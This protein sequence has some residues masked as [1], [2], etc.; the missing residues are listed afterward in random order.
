VGA[1]TGAAVAGRG[2]RF[3][4]GRATIAD[5]EADGDAGGDDEPEA[6]PVVTTV[7]DAAL[8]AALAG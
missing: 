4:V 8:G 1:V 6:D 2:R 5:V 7:A 3:G